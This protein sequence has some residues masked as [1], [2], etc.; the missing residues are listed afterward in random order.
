MG[1]REGGKKA[2]EIADKEASKKPTPYVPDPLS[3]TTFKGKI[4]IVLTIVYD[5]GNRQTKMYEIN[6]L[7]IYKVIE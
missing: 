2:N 5:D 4:G 7:P 1:D 3:P 6:L